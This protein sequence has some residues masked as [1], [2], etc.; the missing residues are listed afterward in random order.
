MGSPIIFLISVILALIIL[1]ITVKSVMNSI[2][3]LRYQR[4]MRIKPFALLGILIKSLLGLLFLVIL[5]LA[6]FYLGNF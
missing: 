3:V 5:Y 1:F 6:N 4:T 2:E